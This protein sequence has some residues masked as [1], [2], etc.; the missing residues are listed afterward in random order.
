M[1]FEDRIRR[2]ENSGLLGDKLVLPDGTE[3]PHANGEIFDALLAAIRGEEHRLL[4]Y[5]VRAQGDL[6]SLFRAFRGPEDKETQ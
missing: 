4:P 2:I 3:V 6:G 1:S 5:L